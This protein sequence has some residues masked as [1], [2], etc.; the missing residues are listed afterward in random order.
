VH[1]ARMLIL[2]AAVTIA[3]IA[4]DLRDLVNRRKHS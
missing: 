4:L 1:P 2:V 3:L